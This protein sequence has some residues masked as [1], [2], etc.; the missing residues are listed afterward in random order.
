MQNRTWSAGILGFTAVGMLAVILTAKPAHAANSNGPYYAEPAWDQ[1]LPVQNRF[2]VLSNWNNEAVLDRETGLVWER[3]PESTTGVW[4][5]MIGVCA[6]KN[7]GGRKGWRMP[8]FAELAS[9]IEPSAKN[10]ALPAD[11]PFANVTLAAYWSATT[12]A[13]V[14]TTAWLVDFRDALVGSIIKTISLHVWC[15]R[16][17]MHE[18]LY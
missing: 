12:R 17:P 1:K 11:H 3:V 9:L 10:P 6:N 16:G 18:S 7:V 15:V 5:A 14:P 13:E 4:N 2:L 8:A